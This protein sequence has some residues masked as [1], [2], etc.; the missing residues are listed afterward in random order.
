[1][2]AGVR[3]GRARLPLPIGVLSVALSWAVLAP[4]AWPQD[5]GGLIEE[6]VV[7]ATKREQ[8]LYEVPASLSVFDGDELGERGIADL[9]DVG[10]FVPNLAVTT[11]S[12]GHTSSANP[13][14][15]GIGMQDHLIT[16]DPGIGVYVDGVYLG[17]QVGQHWNLSNIERV[18]VLRGP[19]GT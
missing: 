4:G 14:I 15:R 18:E 7:T 8:G 1:M 10:K 9:V 12:A 11:F 6:V 16:T 19:Q 2:D 13:F 17:R 3:R 5:D